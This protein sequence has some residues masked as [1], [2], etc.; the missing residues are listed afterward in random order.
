MGRNKQKPKRK[1]SNQSYNPACSL[2]LSHQWKIPQSCSLLVSFPAQLPSVLR[3]YVHLSQ[4]ALQ[5]CGFSSLLVHV[6]SLVSLCSPCGFLHL[7][8]LVSAYA[9]GSQCFSRNQNS[10]SKLHTI[11]PDC[12]QDSSPRMF[13]KHLKFSASK[14]QI[15]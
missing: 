15:H 1:V 7:V 13:H 3:P 10:V 6:A 4:S 12:L 8:P 2:Q 5:R 11:K 14:N 9:D